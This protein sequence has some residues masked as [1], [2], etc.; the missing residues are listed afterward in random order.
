MGY[1]FRVWRKKV[2]VPGAFFMAL[3]VPGCRVEAA[4]SFPARELLKAI[5]DLESRDGQDSPLRPYV[6]YRQS[7]PSAPAVEWDPYAAPFSARSWLL[8]NLSSEKL[9][10]LRNNRDDKG[11]K[12][13]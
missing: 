1:S 4:E 10:Q 11:Q 3:V 8:L 13:L 12:L 9:E 7:N 6:E 5:K 2:L